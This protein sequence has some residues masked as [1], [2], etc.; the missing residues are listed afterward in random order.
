MNN[1]LDNIH[2]TCM[3]CGDSVS[4]PAWDKTDAG[5]YCYTCAMSK[6]G[7]IPSE[8]RKDKI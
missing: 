4:V 3:K 7:E 2:A 6:L 5:Y 8:R 1:S